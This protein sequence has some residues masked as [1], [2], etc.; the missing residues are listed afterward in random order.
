MQSSL[1]KRLFW[2]MG[3][4]VIGT[5]YLLTTYSLKDAIFFWLLMGISYQLNILSLSFTSFIAFLQF[6][7]KL[8]LVVSDT[9]FS[10]LGKGAEEVYEHDSNNMDIKEFTEHYELLAL[11]A[12]S[13]VWYK[14]DKGEDLGDAK[15]PSWGGWPKK[16]TARNIVARWLGYM[17][18]VV[19]EF[20]SKSV[21]KDK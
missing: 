3:I 17:D 16:I 11:L 5:I 6:F 7:T 13:K 10:K 1:Q 2:H 9:S 14:S 19:S 21:K 12:N 4:T 20:L 8:A 18:P 15:P